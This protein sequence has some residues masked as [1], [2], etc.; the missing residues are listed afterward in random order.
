MNPLI[1]KKCYNLITGYLNK[2]MTLLEI[3]SGGSTINFCKLVKK[4]Y[5]VESND[6]WYDIVNK[7]IEKLSID[8]V[9]YKFIKSNELDKNVGGIYWTYK[10]YE[11]YINYVSTLNTKFDIIFIDGMARQYCYLSCFNYIK[12][13]GYVIIHDFYNNSN[14][15]RMWNMDLLN[16]YYIE[17]NSIKE[18]YG[19]HKN[20]ERG[21]DV[22][23]LKKKNIEYDITDIKILDFRLKKI[24]YLENPLH[25]N[26]TYNYYNEFINYLKRFCIFEICTPSNVV[27]KYKSFNPDF[28]FVGFGIFDCGNSS[29]NL[30]LKFINKPIYYILNKEYAA[31]NKKLDWIKN[32]KCEKILTVHHNVNYIKEYSNCIVDRFMW[33]CNNGTFKK[34]DDIYKYDLIFSGVIRKDQ[35]DNLRGKI[36]NILF[37]IQDYKIY[38]TSSR[39]LNNVDYAKLLNWGKI[40]LVTT[41]PADLVG[42]RFFEIMAGN[43]SM[44]LCNRMSKDIYDNYLIDKFNC[45]MFDNEN[46]FIDKFEYYIHHEQERKIIVNNAYDYFNNNLTWINQISKIIKNIK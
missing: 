24:L 25:L 23:I 43:K 15:Q 6:Y 37:K 28:V 5:S 21:N 1:S 44:I 22:I 12:E 9:N 20:T 11:D 38:F 26:S 17:I 42:T 45:I 41:G 2:D 31:L 27:N 35:T 46:D 14:M 18:C 34:Y 30:N 33:S 32:N 16:K 29:P 36:S 10:M 19:K 39:K 7:N 13:D 3:G 40:C 8:N 4:M